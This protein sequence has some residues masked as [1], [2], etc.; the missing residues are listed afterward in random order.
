MAKETKTSK[1]VKKQVKKPAK[2]VLSKKKSTKQVKSKTKPKKFAKVRSKIRVPRYFKDSWREVKKVTWP[3]RKDA[4]KF[5]FAV[6]VFTAIFALFTSL[7]DFG[8]NQLVE[9]IF[10]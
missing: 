1:P 2:K 9:R 8:F 6:I 7:L 4:V 3:T 10:L 5:S